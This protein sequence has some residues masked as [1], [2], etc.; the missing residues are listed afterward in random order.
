[1]PT[2]NA[3]KVVQPICQDNTFGSELHATAHDLRTNL[4]YPVVAMGILYW[5]KT[6]LTGDP[7]SARIRFSSP[8][9]Y[10][11]DAT[12]YVTSIKTVRTPFLLE[13][14]REI[15]YRHPLQVRRYFHKKG[16]IMLMHLFSLPNSE[17]P[18]SMC[19]KSVSP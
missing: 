8:S 10:Y 13:L 18:C 15:A 11:T 1:M 3:L 9:H 7:H 16:R 6:N 12:Y 17:P 2:M 4:A 19:C 14:L 5:I